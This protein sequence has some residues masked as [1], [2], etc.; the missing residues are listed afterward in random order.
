MYYLLK[1]TISYKQSV[2]TATCT[3]ITR[4]QHR[5]TKCTNYK[6]KGSCLESVEWNIMVEGNTGILT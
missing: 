3:K 6:V 4:L 5:E 2:A 1:I